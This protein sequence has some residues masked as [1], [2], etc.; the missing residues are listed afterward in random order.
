VLCL[1]VRSQVVKKE[2]YKVYEIL[3]LKDWQG[4]FLMC[5]KSLNYDLQDYVIFLI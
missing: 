3:I 1:P 5:R 2:S 4:A